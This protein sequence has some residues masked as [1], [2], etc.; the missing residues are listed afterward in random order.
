VAAAVIPR[1]LNDISEK[2]SDYPGR[3][4][5]EHHFDLLKSFALTSLVVM[6]IIGGIS[7]V[8]FSNYLSESLLRSNAEVSQSFAY[9]LI[10]VEGGA[11]MF[12]LGPDEAAAG[13]DSRYDLPELGDHI[14]TTPGVVRTNIYSR[15]GVVLWSSQQGFVG[16][17]FAENQELEKALKGE[18][19][20]EVKSILEEQKPEY[21]N[22]GIEVSRVVEN[23]L[24]II[25]DDGTV[26]AV[27]EMYK[28]PKRLFAEIESARNLVWISVAT[29]V[30]FL[31]ACLFWIIYRAN[32][33]IRD[34]QLRLVESET[35]VAIGEMASTVAHS[36][37]NPLAAMR[38]SAELSTE[39]SRDPAVRETSEDIITQIDR[40]ELWLRELLTYSRSEGMTHI[41]NADLAEII[42]HCI[43]GH[44]QVIRRS[45]IQ[46]VV[47]ID[48]DIPLVKGDS[49]LLGQMFNSILDNAIDAM[50]DGGRLKVKVS[51]PENEKVV[52]VQ[53]IDSGGG[54]P[55]DRLDLMFESSLTTKQNGL[56]IGMMLVKKIA[57]RHG[58]RISLR[59]QVGT[60]T[61]V[62]C[63]FPVD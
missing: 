49:S 22:F 17:K 61:I 28:V 50:A 32:R 46:P 1:K 25:D 24:P 53:I 47:E 37:R 35:M 21:A 16:R 9:S 38:S 7:G 55:Q 59:S 43:Q 40:V 62:T 30:V 14:A 6:I 45:V 23:Y 33:V 26:L 29:A 36:I 13:T 19:V 57:D 11:G 44:K 2:N 41:L 56:G 52:Q 8:V 54:I 4:K 48:D 63:S 31:Y 10:E 34:Q 5:G 27:V 18:I 60:G 42:R 39:I 12:L 51:V 15:D 20:F 58:A 3:S